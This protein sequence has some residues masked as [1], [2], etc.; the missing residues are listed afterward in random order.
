MPLS[1]TTIGAFPK[2]DFLQLPDWFS[3]RDP[4]AAARVTTS[5]ANAQRALGDRLESDLQRA[6]GEVISDQVA[7]GILIP[8]DGEVPRENYLHYH[9]RHL[10]GIDFDNLTSKSL[11]A[12]QFETMLPTWVG[13]VTTRD[14]FLNTDYLRAQ[15]FTSLPVKITVPGPL[16]LSESTA[17]QYYPTQKEH[18]EALADAL[19]FEI[20]ALAAAGCTQI[21]IDEPI[22]ARKVDTALEFGIDNLERVFHGIDRRV[23]RTLHICCG[24]PYKLDEDDYP[25]ADQNAYQQLAPALEASCID[26]ISIE[27]AHRHNDLQLLESFSNKKIVLGVVAIAKSRVETVDEIA[28]RLQTACGHID[29]DRLIAAPDCGLGFLGRALSIAKLGNLGEAA[30]RL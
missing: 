9:C 14:N 3:A 5:Y 25:K 16:T 27:D 26:C 6:A 19:N 18:C 23:T 12:G 10:G 7:A 20:K 1:T 13:P 2:P 24:Y 17:N 28:T 21:Q 30:R 15:A 29:A 4:Q 11:R 22:F 8:T